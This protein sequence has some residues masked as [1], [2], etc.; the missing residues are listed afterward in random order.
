MEEGLMAAV[1][2]SLCAL[3]AFFCA[4]LLA[5]S[6][7]RS[8]SVML[9]WSAACFACLTVA[10]ILLVLDRI[11]LPAVDLSLARLAVALVA[12]LLLLYGLIMEG[13]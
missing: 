9:F 12:V 11:V 13:D 4:A 8:R 7:R 2:Y 10:N 6:F 5:R 3:T 1:I